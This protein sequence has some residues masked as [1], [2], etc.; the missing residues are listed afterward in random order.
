MAKSKRRCC[1]P[2]GCGIAGLTG[3]IFA[4]TFAIGLPFLVSYIVDQVLE[5]I[6]RIANR[7]LKFGIFSCSYFVFASFLG[8]SN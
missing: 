8:G 2:V 7:N 6:C 5:F 1:G 3:A 4:A